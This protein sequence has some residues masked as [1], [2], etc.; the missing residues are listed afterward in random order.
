MPYQKR[1]LTKSTADD[2]APVAPLG[3]G[4]A[5]LGN[6]LELDVNADA[7]DEPELLEEDGLIEGAEEVELEYVDDNGI[8]VPEMAEEVVME[9]DYVEEY[10]EEPMQE[11]DMAESLV[12]LSRS[13][14]YRDKGGTEYV[15]D[16]LE[17]RRQ[18]RI[19][20]RFTT[21]HQFADQG[22]VE[23][24]HILL[25]EYQPVASAGRDT[26][27]TPKYPVAVARRAMHS[28]RIPFARSDWREDQCKKLLVCDVFESLPEH[29]Q[30][31]F[32]K[33][34]EIM[35]TSVP[36]Y[37]SPSKR[38]YPENSPEKGNVSRLQG[39]YADTDADS[40][41][42]RHAQKSSRLSS[43][44]GGRLTDAPRFVVTSPTSR[45]TRVLAMIP[46]EEK[47]N[48]ENAD[49]VD[50]ADMPE[51]IQNDVHEQ[52][53]SVE[54][55][56][57]E[58]GDVDIE[59]YEEDTSRE[60]RKG[61]LWLDS[62]GRVVDVVPGRGVGYPGMREETFGCPELRV[63]SHNKDGQDE[64][65]CP[66][67]KM[68]MKRSIYYHH[69]RLI[70]KY[71][72]CDIFTPKRF[73]CG[74]PGCHERL[75]TLERLCEHMFQVHR[76][77]TDIKRKVFENEAQFEEFLRELESRGGNFRMSRGNKTIKEGIVQYFRCNRIFSIAKDK[78]LR[79]VDDINAGTY[80][81]IKDITQPMDPFG[82]ETS[83]KPYLRTEEACTAF[84]R[85]TYLND[86]TIE[87]RY[88]D[89][90]LH[91]DERLRLPTA[92][93]NRIYEMTKK[94]LPLP[95]IVMVLQRECHRFCMPGTA[96]E[97][98]IMAVTPREVQLV[99]QSVQRRLD[100][101]SRRKRINEISGNGRNANGGER[102]EGEHAQDREDHEAAVN[103]LEPAE[104]DDSHENLLEM[105][106][107]G[108]GIQESAL[109]FSS[110]GRG[111]GGE[112]TELELAMLEEYEQNRGVILTDFQSIKREE[113]RKRLCRERVRAK[114][115]T[116][117]R[118]MRNIQFSDFECDLLIR[119]EQ[120]LESIVELWNAR[121][122]AACKGNQDKEL[123][124]LPKHE[125]V[126]DKHG[127]APHK[128]GSKEAATSSQGRGSA[129]V[130]MVTDSSAVAASSEPTDAENSTRS[131]KHL[132]PVEGDAASETTPSAA[133]ASA[134]TMRSSRVRTRRVIRSEKQIK[135]EYPSHSPTPSSSPPA[136]LA[137]SRLGRV[138]KRK[139]ILDV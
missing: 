91:G 136:Q 56:V 47:V 36:G 31:V 10:I 120:M 70:R 64:R 20:R 68:T 27:F 13:G 72:R 46:F 93:R 112:L 69:G 66:S 5:S 132:E 32:K 107:D 22:Y 131:E 82:K 133:P 34:M 85:K 78:A 111:E 19:L 58:G 129:E 134:K 84:F 95:V 128:D 33:L 138:I 28:A 105:Q 121:M 50:N 76:A 74:S 75:G 89:Y 118:A 52:E 102:N 18:P 45:S 3:G 24:R 43:Y 55:D 103:L 41:S 115:Y 100:S 38:K 65:F 21:Q 15:V 11:D 16:N 135:E 71:G 80:E 119:S 130:V 86:G 48:A 63:L 4:E 67:C 99:A 113:N 88:C 37:R 8:P 54:N 9:G 98:R 49:R 39:F 108:G 61:N 12:A 137:V 40:I 127:S 2:V 42:A 92:I 25:D 73:P 122:E 62:K 124:Q 60:Q 97:R 116:L 79:I 81:A 94:R 117:G 57:D 104:A 126:S 30:E 90:H 83:T 53:R 6:E 125:L 26:R 44:V 87:V 17:R 96:L 110:E 139:K 106:E 1:S 7:I 59:T 14:E 23:S 51:L 109:D 35:G 77:P 101:A 29:K 114:I 123:L